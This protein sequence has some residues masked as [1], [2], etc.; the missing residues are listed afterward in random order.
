MIKKEKLLRYIIS[1][2][3]IVLVVGGIFTATLLSIPSSSVVAG[4]G[5]I[6]KGSSTDS[7]SLMINVY[8]GTEHIRPM[9]N[10]LNDKNVKATFFIGGSWA[11]DNEELLKEIYLEG[12]EIGS[13]GYFHKAHSKLSREGNYQEI[14]VTH[15]LIKGILNFDMNLFAPPSGDYSDTTVEV[16]KELGYKTILWTKDT[17]DWRDQDAGLIKDRA[18]SDLS[19]GNLILMHPTQKT[20]EA[21][22]LIIDGIKEKGYLLKTVSEVL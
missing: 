5:P 6:R 13:H 8:W 20:K 19:G 3:V 12:H 4:D 10:I 9:L 14:N 7:I 21:L 16:A 18:T 17:I 15:K 22:P 1:N 2:L 11:E